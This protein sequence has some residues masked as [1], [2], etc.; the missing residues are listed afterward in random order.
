MNTKTT[1]GDAK[2]EKMVSNTYKIANVKESTPVSECNALHKNEEWKC[3][4]IEY[5]YPAIK[6]RFMVVNSEYD[7]WAIPNILGVGCLKNAMVGGQTLASCSS[8]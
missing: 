6:G 3:L 5:A 7:S 4:F 1:L 2:I 8:K